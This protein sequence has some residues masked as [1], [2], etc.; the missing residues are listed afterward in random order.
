M[1]DRRYGATST[2]T[3]KV[4]CRVATT[5]AITLSG[6]QTIDGVVLNSGD[7][8][9]VMNQADQT[10]NGIYNCLAGAWTRDT[11]FNTSLLIIQGTLILITEG[12][13]SSGIIY[14]L[15]TANP[16]TLGTSNL[17]FVLY[18][19]TNVS[20]SAANLHG[21]TAK[22]SPTGADEL[23]I[24]DSSLG[25]VLKKFTLTNLATY[26][27]SLASAGWNAL[28]STSSN[29]LNSATTTIVVNGAT[30]PVVGQVLTAL[31]S[32]TADWENP[33]ALTTSPIKLSAIECVQAAGALTVSSTTPYLD[34]HNVSLTN[35]TPA[36]VGGAPANL[37]VPLAASLGLITAVSG[38]I[39]IAEMNNAGTREIAIAN[40]AGGLQMDETNLISTTAISASA[41]AANVWYSTTAR[42]NLAYRIVGAFDI[43]WTTGGVGY[44]SPTTKINAGG[45]ALTAMSSLGYGQTWQALTL[46]SGTTYYNIWGKP[47][48]IS[49]QIDSNFVSSVSVNGYAMAGNSGIAGQLYFDVPKNQSFVVTTTSVMSVKAVLR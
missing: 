4:P 27:S 23:P 17:T 13:V 15:T 32:T 24:L 43:V 49:L 7:R 41:T 11:D 2:L 36:T 8:V 10:T 12:L 1:A 20:L 5:A 28:T 22:P 25:Y 34:F 18:D 45:N 31:S 46:V 44:S 26:L 14:Q 38:R 16:I 9:L 37:T 21:A 19:Y 39:I 48:A 3:L 40:Q 29:A 42:T 35:G 30:A 47:V 33:S 6:L